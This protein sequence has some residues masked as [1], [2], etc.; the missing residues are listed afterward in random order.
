MSGEWWPD[1]RRPRA[2]VYPLRRDRTRGP[3]LSSMPAEVITHLDEAIAALENATDLQRAVA[4]M[5]ADGKM[6]RV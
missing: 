6:G 1:G 3:R 5:N 2:A 4:A